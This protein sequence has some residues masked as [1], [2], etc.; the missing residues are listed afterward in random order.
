LESSGEIVFGSGAEGDPAWARLNIHTD[1]GVDNALTGLTDGF[2]QYQDILKKRYEG[3]E[4]IGSRPL[5]INNA[6]VVFFGFSTSKLQGKGIYV[7]N[8]ET[9]IGVECVS[10]EGCFDQFSSAFSSL[11]LSFSLR[12]GAPQQFI[13][14]PLPD[15]GMQQLALANRAE[16]ARRV[17][18][19]AKLARMLLAA[20][21]VKP[22]NLFESVQDFR[23]A[24]QLAIAPPVRLPDCRSLA[25]GLLD[26]TKEYNR[27]LARQ[28]FEINRALNDGD[29]PRA[30]WEATKMMQMVTDK[31]DPAYQ[32]AFKVVQSIQ[33]PRGQ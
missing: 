21:D 15:D 30:Y 31:T 7:L 3:F 11:L 1:K 33:R 27:A 25:Q 14:F 8:A 18:A 12:D 29:N 2:N 28:R 13:E 16:V 6:T 24:L 4:L 22:D 17:D 20:K 26:A 23:K 10:P 19:Y 5:N 32:E 9:R